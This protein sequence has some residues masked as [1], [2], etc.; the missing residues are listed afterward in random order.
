MPA[1]ELVVDDRPTAVHPHPAAELFDASTFPASS[2]S[3]AGLDPDVLPAPE[4][5]PLEPSEPSPLPD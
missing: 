4:L 2:T 5:E 1:A 3:P